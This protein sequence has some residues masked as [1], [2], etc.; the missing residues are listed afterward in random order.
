[1]HEIWIEAESFRDLGGWVVDSGSMETLHSAYV[2]AHGMGT[3]V[4]DAK[5]E[6]SVPADGRYT[7]W[8]RTRDYTA[9]WGVREPLGRF[10][11]AVDGDFLPEVLGTA[12]KEWAWQKAGQA[13][14]SAGRHTL[15]LHD[16]TGFNG[17]CD[18]LYLTDGDTPPKQ[19][20]AAV[21]EMRRRLGYGDI[22]DGGHYDL[23]VAGG[24]IAGIC[25]AYAALRSGVR[26]L[27]IHDRAMLG[28]CNSSEVRVC[29]GG[30]IHLPPYP[31]LGNVVGA[32]GPISGS[33]ATFPAEYYEDDRKKNLFGDTPAL[34]D[35][36]FA[37]NERVTDVEKEG[38]CITAVI[39]TH[40]RTGK[41]KRYTAPLFADCTGDGTLAR[42]GGAAVMYGRE[43]RAAFGES[44][45]P[46]TG[47][48]L[49]M[50]H[51]LR[52][53]SE[54]T[55]EEND[56]PD[57]DWNLPFTDE[58]C[59]HCTSGDWEQETGFRRDMVTEIEEIRDYGLRAV[60]AN[61][62]FQKYHAKDRDAYRR[63]C[64]AW[65]SPIGG[66]RESYRVVG[67]HILTQ[68]DIEEKIPY[69]DGTAC[70]TWSI[71][72]HFPE[73]QNE[74]AFGE[75]FRSFAYHRGIV[76]PYPVPY[77]CL[78]ARDIGNL[79]LGGRI[80][81]A[82]HVAFSCARVMRTLGELG[83]VIGMA[84][85]ICR[86]HACSPREV[87]SRY[88]SDLIAAM[89]KGIPIEPPFACTVGEEE[90]YHFKDIGWLN[91]HPY[92]A[93]TPEALEKFRRGIKALGL[94]HKYPLPEEL[95]KKD[96]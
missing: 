55:G 1:M 95:T 96:R 67:D 76:S 38:G 87:Y 75:A 90:A 14:L 47:E 51:S 15:A 39:T 36:A 70:L 21:E 82:S 52:W 49:V 6:F 4:P 61:W 63:R 65:V 12:G 44:L 92:H 73:P 59:L 30:M 77:R 83:E 34:R 17:R 41:K 78:Y 9:A 62:A 45:A 33:P 60:Y 8:A 84:A 42:L 69:P 7:V 10:S 29:M 80:L 5:T 68:N 86:R 24:G 72:M 91:L 13:T 58:T 85:G 50:G 18:C 31:N 40:T 74:A 94:S 57:V 16:L 48:K 20:G 54:E 71:D 28:G 32:I 64:L 19:D 23:I 88:L 35:R 79:F 53:Y 22:T 26:V 11:L 46:P 43:A 27:L 66:K 37:L 25:A 56:F 89:E 81:S 3:P 93:E 2:M